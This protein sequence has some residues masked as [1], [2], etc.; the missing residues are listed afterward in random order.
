MRATPALLD[1]DA[2]G[3]VDAEKSVVNTPEYATQRQG[4]CSATP[5]LAQKSLDRIEAKLDKL[6]GQ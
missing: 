1:S 2:K 5:E 3:F 6:L 4:I